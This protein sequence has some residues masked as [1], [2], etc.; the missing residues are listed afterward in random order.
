M[1]DEKDVKGDPT[2]VINGFVKYSNIN[3]LENPQNLSPYSYVNNNPLRY[4]DPGS[5]KMVC[6]FSIDRSLYTPFN[7]NAVSALM[8]AASL[9]RWIHRVRQLGSKNLRERL[10]LAT[11]SLDLTQKYLETSAVRLEAGLRLPKKASS[12]LV[13]RSV[14]RGIRS[15]TYSAT[16]G[17]RLRLKTT[18]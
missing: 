12:I 16:I 15:T 3:Y 5:W 14:W 8:S 10:P 17:I 13:T 9:L 7:F 2:H 6:R 18:R 1:G 4:V 11:Y